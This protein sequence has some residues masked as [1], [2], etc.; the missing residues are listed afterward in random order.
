MIFCRSLSCRSSALTRAART[1]SLER[2]KKSYGVFYTSSFRKVCAL[3][4]GENP[5]SQ[6]KSLSNTGETPLP[7][8]RRNGRKIDALVTTSHLFRP[9]RPRKPA[10]LLPSWLRN[11]D[12]LGS[13]CNEKA[14]G[15]VAR[16]MPPETAFTDHLTRKFYPKWINLKKARAAPGHSP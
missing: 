11:F 16:R 1:N 6:R 13:N 9:N 15:G 2:L 12:F 5:F 3:I 7:P 14:P 8:K 4:A 10:S